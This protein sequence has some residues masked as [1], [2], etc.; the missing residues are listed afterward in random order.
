MIIEEIIKA[1]Q[2]TPI[3]ILF[4]VVGL[5]IIVL[6]FVTKIGGAIEVSPEQRRWAI[7]VGIFLLILGLVLNFSNVTPPPP[8][9]SKQYWNELHR[10]ALKWDLTTAKRD[11]AELAKSEDKCIAEFAKRFEHE[12][13]DKGEEGFKRINRIKCSINDQLKCQLQ[14]TKFDFSPQCP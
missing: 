12:L 14:V 4:I 2:S 11:L 6:A 9:L 13:N 10:V 5:F 3:P 7:P 8:D 1:I